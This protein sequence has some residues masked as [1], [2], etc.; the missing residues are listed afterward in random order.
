MCGI[1]GYIGDRNATRAEGILRRMVRAIERRG[2]DGEGI[3]HWEQAWLG[4][5]RLAIL[6]LSE[7]GRQPML[8]DCGRVGVV[9]N[10]CIYNFMEI[11][12]ELEGLGHRFRSLCDTEV[13]VRGYQQWGVDA[14]AAKMRGMFAIGVWDEDRQTLTLLRDRL[15]VKPLLYA[16]GE[17]RIAF[18]S[19]LPALQETGMAGDLNPAAMLEYL[20][21]GYVTD[22]FTIHEGV[23]KLGAGE[24]LEW[25][26]GE[27][28]KRTYWRLPDEAEN[29]RVSFEEAVEETERLLLESVKLRLIADVKVGALLSGGIDSALVCWAVRQ[30][31][32]DI[33]AFTV[34]MEGD[35]SDETPATRETARILGIP[36]Q[37][38]SLRRD[39]SGPGD[40]LHEVTS[41]Y[42]EP[43]AAQSAM[44]L[45]Q[46]S[47][48]VKPHA[49]VL[50]TGD[51][52]DDLF[53]GYWFY[54]TYLKSQ[55]IARLL[56]ELAGDLW[57]AGRGIVDTIPALRRP[58]HFADYIT[59][60]LGG[61][62]RANDGLPFYTRRGLLGERLSGRN[63]P[64][65]EI[66][67]SVAAGRSMMK[68]LLQYQQR[69]WFVSEF[70]TK[71]D[72]GTMYHALEARAPFLDQKLW[73]FAAQLPA[74][75]RLHGGE[76]KAVLREIV[77]RRISPEVASRKK[78]GFTV[79][80]ERWMAGP[81]RDAFRRVADAPLLE[82]EGWLTRGALAKVASELG[83]AEQSS[84]HVW[85]LMVLEN[86]LRRHRGVAA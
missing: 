40:L 68:D 58:K 51:G 7:A 52:G 3:E 48:A 63:L 41:A 37:V 54:P 33:T 1:A 71:V 45:L 29:S 18:G 25:K 16:T 55:Q 9:F 24:I 21:F 84:K 61:F 13:V 78:Q 32:A 39:D 43:F 30:A 59:G 56:P 20:E 77:R 38:I 35:P 82:Q 67:L 74:S 28:R 79:P 65:R 44:A 42:G 22:A 6:D 12:A 8:S 34:S 23:H 47:A 64:Q 2:P 4:H 46:V 19:T 85:F 26:N 31:Q 60:G 14:L 5:R 76:L 70:M 73:E 57:R 53:L 11:R 81:W 27:I 75:L 15:G 66:P 80:I 10:G 83:Q 72:G 62:T 50:L 86:W 49:T 17:G 36:H 69:T